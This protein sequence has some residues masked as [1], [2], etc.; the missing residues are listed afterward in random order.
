MPYEQGEY[1][2]FGSEMQAMYL[3]ACWW[4]GSGQ[5]LSTNHSTEQI[6]ESPVRGPPGSCPVERFNQN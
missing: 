2:A 1:A 5:F 6:L 4:C 3:S